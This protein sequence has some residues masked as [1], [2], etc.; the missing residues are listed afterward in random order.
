MSNKS[1]SLFSKKSIAGAFALLLL[2]L[3]GFIQFSTGD[4]RV[5]DN[6][7]QQDTRQKSSDYYDVDEIRYKGKKIILTKHAKCRM[8]CREIDAYEVGEILDSGRINQRKSSP[9]AKP[10]PTYS[11][12]GQSRDGPTVRIVIADCRD[13]VKIITVIDL[14]NDYKCHCK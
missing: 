1:H 3:V 6:R 8:G 2:A 12:E 7:N 5:V 9:D 10:C 13:V 4:A 11:L 14:D